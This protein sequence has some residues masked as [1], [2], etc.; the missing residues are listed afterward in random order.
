MRVG[1]NGSALHRAPRSASK[2]RTRAL[3]ALAAL[4]AGM[5]REPW[6]RI[7]MAAKAA[8]LDLGDF[9]EWSRPVLTI[10]SN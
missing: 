7:A 10:V 5:K 9:T 8:G 4:D 3:D 6:V 2:D 1:A